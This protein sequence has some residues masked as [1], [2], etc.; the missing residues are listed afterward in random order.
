MPS[1]GNGTS[2]PGDTPQEVLFI[3]TDGVNDYDS[4]GRL[5]AP[6]DALNKLCQT[7]KLRGIRI[8]F[9]YTTYNPL[10]TNAFYN[11]NVAPFQPQIATDAQNCAS[12]GLF[13]QVNTDGDI[14]AAMQALFQE[15]VA[16][17]FLKQ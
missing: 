3:V 17:A 8:A 6:I 11:Q 1:P 2:N 12:P 14:S 7:I 15:A 13:F 10:P 4:N 9:L 16:T 5:I